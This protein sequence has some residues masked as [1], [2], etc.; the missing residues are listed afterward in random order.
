MGCKPVIPSFASCAGPGVVDDTCNSLKEALGGV[1]LPADSIKIPYCRL[2]LAAEV[3]GGG[4]GGGSGCCCRW[5]CWWWWG[6][7]VRLSSSS[8]LLLLLQLGWGRL[9][10]RGVGVS[11]STSHML[12]LNYR[13]DSRRGSFSQHCSLLWCGSVLIE[14]EPKHPRRAFPGMGLYV[15]KALLEQRW[16][17]DSEGFTAQPRKPIFS[18]TRAAAGAF[19]DTRPRYRTSEVSCSTY[20][21]PRFSSSLGFH[22]IAPWD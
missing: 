9:G 13:S 6:Q 1:D 7:H 12:N 22:G 3:D 21:P 11:L 19:P 14:P 2:H 5:W 4:A 20:L 8:V 18:N 16:R 15:H 10:V 17:K